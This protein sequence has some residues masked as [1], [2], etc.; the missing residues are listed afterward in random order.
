MDFQYDDVADNILLSY[1]QI[2]NIY[3]L[4]QLWIILQI[5]VH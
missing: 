2:D 3:V 5:M 4:I 1:L